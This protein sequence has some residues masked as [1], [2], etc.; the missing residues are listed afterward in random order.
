M[1]HYGETV[2]LPRK[3]RNTRQGFTLVELLVVIAII[4]ILVGLLLPAVQAAREAAR[5]MSCQ[6]NIRQVGI[7]MHNFESTYKKLP[8]A[9]IQLGGTLASPNTELSQFQKVG[10]TGLL[11]AH[12]AQ[13]S[14]LGLILPYI[15][16]TN[17]LNAGSAGGYNIKLDWYDPVNRPA[18]ASVIPMYVCPSNPR[19]PGTIDTTQLGSSDRTLVASNGD[20]FPATTDYMAVNRTT[21]TAAVWN[22]VTNNLPVYPGNEAVLGMM[23]SNRFTRFATV[24]DGLSNTIMVAEA[25][26]RPS[27]YEMGKALEAYAAGTFGT[28]STAYINGAWAQPGNVIAVDGASVQTVSGILRAFNLSASNVTVGTRCTLNCTNQGEI[29]AFHS[30]GANITAGDASTRFL[31]ATTDLKTLYLM[32]ARSDGEVISFEP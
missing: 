16:Q 13:S 10:T 14:F 29:Y 4:G 3:L 26:G 28:P 15:E 17:V 12:Y 11:G 18:S 31:A 22:A 30:G 8:P 20:W 32:V 21:Q 23:A 24:T 7:A 25:A 9:G 5:R 27:R 19:N 2:F 1:S 6:N